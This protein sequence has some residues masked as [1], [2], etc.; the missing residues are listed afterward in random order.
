MAPVCRAIGA[1]T[2]PSSVVYPWLLPGIRPAMSAIPWVI[3]YLCSAALV[4]GGGVAFAARSRR[5]ERPTPSVTVG[6]A[7]VA[8]AVWPLLVVGLAQWLLVH[9]IVKALRRAP[10]HTGE[11][12]D[13]SHPR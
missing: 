11:V 12:V 8:G 2:R 10:V 7:L 6:P 5:S 9:G 3:V 13:Q 4:A 1:A